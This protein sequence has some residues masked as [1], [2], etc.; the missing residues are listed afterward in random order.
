MKL[1]LAIILTLSA[2][3]ALSK[4]VCFERWSVV[5]AIGDEYGE[6]QQS[7]SL[8]RSKNAIEVFANVKTGSWSILITKATGVSCLVASGSS[9]VSL[10]GS[11]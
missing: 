5:K 4:T 3:P 6:V 10:D 2:Y 1:I 8:T 9:Y 7:I 11:K